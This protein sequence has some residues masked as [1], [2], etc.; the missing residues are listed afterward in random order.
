MKIL[1]VKIDNLG[2]DEALQKAE[3][4][5]LDEQQRYIVTPNPEFLVRAQKDQTY[6]QILNQADLAV[7]D[8]IGLVL[9]A[10]FLKQPL[11]QRITGVDL[12]EQICQQAAKKG[13]QVFL[14]GA[15]P[16]PAVALAAA[17]VLRNKYPGL[18][19]DLLGPGNQTTPT[20]LFVALGSPKQEKWIAHYLPK[21]PQVDLAIGVGGAFDFIS[22]RVK[23]APTLVQKIGLEWLWRLA[24]QPW[25]WPRIYQAVIVFPWLVLKEKWTK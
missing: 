5:L 20:I 4:L 24:K 1:G 3:D 15:R 10:R 21:L 14:H 19:I 25:R 22:G 12:M 18:K 16:E 11:K 7:A 23:R 9:A 6:R 17:Q 2:T 8:G 13:W